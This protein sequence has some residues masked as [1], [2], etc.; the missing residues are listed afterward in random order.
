MNKNVAWFVPYL[1]KTKMAH[2][3][4]MV[5]RG[6]QKSINCFE[7]LFSKSFLAFLSEVSSPRKMS[8]ASAPISVDLIE[9]I[10]EKVIENGNKIALNLISRRR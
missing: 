9:L 10:D 8:S 4:G 7:K 6:Y 3:L 1:K 5:G 2:I